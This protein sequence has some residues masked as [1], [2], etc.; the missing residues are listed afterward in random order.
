MGLG[1]GAYHGEGGEGEGILTRFAIVTG[2]VWNVSVLTISNPS[3][4]L[5]ED[6]CEQRH[7]RSLP[8]QNAKW[9]IDLCISWISSGGGGAGVDIISIKSIKSI[10]P[11]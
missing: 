2:A 8:E 4:S 10:R 6:V 11:P 3:S 9:T 1:W 5:F 7:D